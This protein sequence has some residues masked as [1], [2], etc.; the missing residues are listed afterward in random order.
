MQ[1]E[2]ASASNAKAATENLLG[3]GF[4]VGGSPDILVI[5]SLRRTQIS[6]PER[7]EA[8][9]TASI[10]KRLQVL[11]QPK[12]AGCSGTVSS[13]RNVLFSP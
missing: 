13:H 7:S 3:H 4:L 8:S 11:S 5:A 1:P 12:L 2:G 6:L 9:H 10:D